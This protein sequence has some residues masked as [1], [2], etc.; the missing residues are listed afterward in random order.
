MYLQPAGKSETHY[1]EMHLNLSVWSQEY[2]ENTMCPCLYTGTVF[3]EA[4]FC[5]SERA[6]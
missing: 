5:Y 6:K 1:F 4:I 3:I 2:C